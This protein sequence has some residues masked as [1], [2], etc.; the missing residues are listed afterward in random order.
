MG[1]K[2]GAAALSTDCAAAAIA[3]AC[4]EVL[5]P[6]ASSSG[7]R[8]S[9][10]AAAAFMSAPDSYGAAA[11]AHGPAA[12]LSV[13]PGGIEVA[14]AVVGGDGPRTALGSELRGTEQKVKE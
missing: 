9:G 2:T 10:A 3:T 14:A 4:N 12:L 1:V 8:A 11:V 7:L 6:I 5:T 13:N